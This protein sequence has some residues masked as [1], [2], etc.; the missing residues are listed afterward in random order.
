[1]PTPIFG[2]TQ[3]AWTV[4]SP[5]GSFGMAAEVTFDVG[6]VIGVGFPHHP[7]GEGLTYRATPIRSHYSPG[8]TS[9]SVNRG[10]CPQDL[11]ADLQGSSR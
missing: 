8:D 1:M 5:A 11:R 2:K 9:R 10:G 6:S 3:A 4:P 7:G